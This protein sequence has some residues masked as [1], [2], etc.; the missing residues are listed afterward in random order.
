MLACTTPKYDLLYERW[1]NKPD[2]L[3]RL[4]EF[5]P[6]ERLLDLCGGTGAVARAAVRLGARDVHLLDLNPRCLDQNVQQHQGD[7][8][9][10]RSYPADFFDVVVCR[11]AIGYL[12]PFGL[13][14]VLRK[15]MA[16]GG[17]FVFNS[18]VQPRLS[19][20]VYRR[21]QRTYLE[22]SGFFQ[23]QVVHLQ[24]CLPGGLDVSTFRWHGQDLLYRSFA[25]F[26]DV[27]VTRVGRSLHWLCIKAKSI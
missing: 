21:S 20:K 23:T 7:T 8:E 13:A 6:H 15:I 16:P 24:S 4:A 10:A 19:M 26:F 27:S 18:F 17:R 5:R 9:S 12:Y 22:M 3:L 2:T 25:P 1:L 14:A 11:Q